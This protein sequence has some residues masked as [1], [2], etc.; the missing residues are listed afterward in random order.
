[1]TDLR[2]HAEALYDAL[3]RGANYDLETIRK[4]LAAAESRGMMRAADVIGRSAPAAKNIILA[5]AEK[6]DD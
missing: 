1:M 4:H 3:G 5:E 6:D 2:K